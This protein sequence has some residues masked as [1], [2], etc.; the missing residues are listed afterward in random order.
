VAESYVA[1]L[2]ADRDVKGETLVL[3][4][5]LERPGRKT[6]RNLVEPRDMWHGPQ[7]FGFAAFD[8][9]SGAKPIFSQ[10]VR[11]LPIKGTNRA[12]LVTVLN[13]KLGPTGTWSGGTLVLGLQVLGSKRSISN[14][15]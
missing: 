9:R 10:T 2:E 13:A 1:W 11:L 15:S 12:L 3:D 5:M 6:F 8:F 4:L 14:G 7:P